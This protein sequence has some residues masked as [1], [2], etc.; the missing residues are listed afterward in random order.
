[1]TPEKIGTVISTSESPSSTYF[2]FV[3]NTSKENIK[4]GYF[5]QIDT[6]NG[7]LI[8]R[9]DEIIKSNRYFENP[10]S[11]T[12]Y[13]RSGISI[14]DILP[15]SRWESLVARAEVLGISSD[16]MIN[17][18]KFPP[19]PGGEVFFAD[20]EIIAKFL[21]LNTSTGLDI[22]LLEY[23]DI[24]AKIDMTRLFQKH[25]AI[26]AMSGSGKSYLTSVLIEELLDRKEEDGQV[27]VVMIDSHGEY[28]SFAKDRAYMDRV[29]IIDG[30]EVRINIS[31]MTARDL[32]RFIEKELSP[33][34]VRE[35]ERI[36]SSLRKDTQES[37]KFCLD[38]IIK[39]I[40]SDG[41]MKDAT[42]SSLVA[43]LEDLKRNRVFADYSYPPL[44]DIKQGH[45][46]ILD[47]S[48]ILSYRKRDMLVGY[49]AQHLFRSRQRSNIPPYVF[50]IEEAHNFA[51]EAMKGAIAKPIIEVIAR[52]GRKF[53]SGLVLISQRPKRLSTTTISQCNTHIIMRI[54]NP[55]DLQHIANS[56][57]GMS[58]DAI[59]ILPGLRVG[60]AFIIGE[61]TNAPTL[62]KVRQRRS[63][64]PEHSKTL[65]D[66]SKEFRIKDRQM[67]DDL[68]AYM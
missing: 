8:A 36:M 9:I 59:R 53:Y 65:E 50:M 41:V 40:L 15:A 7:Y 52:E 29:K 24:P 35:L 33:L 5:V 57:E 64:E 45:L 25:L 23:Q 20:K 27:A 10:S 16:G 58:Q 12:E 30:S 32:A 60:E 63:A 17:R 19:S 18:P 62:I 54:T 49:L 2:E 42:K 1:M 46:V 51:P 31:K 22:G 38:D 37:G 28:L 44:T 48:S 21:G 13:E 6:D 56:S 26:L 34:Q 55:N 4:K 68:D 61:A 14:N 39:N 3:I 47:L 66:A 11:V 43:D 67:E